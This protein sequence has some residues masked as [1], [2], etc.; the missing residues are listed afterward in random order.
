MKCCFVTVGGNDIKQHVLAV[1]WVFNL[2]NWMRLRLESNWFVFQLQ[3]YATQTIANPS[4]KQIICAIQK[5]LTIN[6]VIIIM[7]VNFH[8]MNDVSI[9]ITILYY[10]NSCENKDAHWTDINRD[11]AAET[12]TLCRHR[13]TS[14]SSW[15]SNSTVISCCRKYTSEIYAHR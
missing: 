1:V 4:N 14:F 3:K 9:Q 10:F 5:V 7:E 8:W 6:A 2:I 11:A 12:C 13:R 15:F